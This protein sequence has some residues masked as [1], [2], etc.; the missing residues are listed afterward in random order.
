MLSKALEQAKK[1]RRLVK[2]VKVSFTLAARV[3]RRTALYRQTLAAEHVLDTCQFR[4]KFSAYT[5]TKRR[6]VLW[7]KR[8][9]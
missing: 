7:F 9:L 4:K 2:T 6:K 3:G 8:V 5:C 1:T